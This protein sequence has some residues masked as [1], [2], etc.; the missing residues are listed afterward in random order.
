L[1]AAV[2]S[3]HVTSAAGPALTLLFVHADSVDGHRLGAVIVVMKDGV[4]SRTASLPGPAGADG[5]DGVVVVN[6]TMV[7]G[8]VRRRCRPRQVAL[9]VVALGGGRSG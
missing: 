9:S 2:R 8:A 5:A 7:A 4:A 3:R 1:S 6:A